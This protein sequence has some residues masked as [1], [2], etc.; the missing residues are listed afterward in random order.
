MSDSCENTDKEIWRERPGDFYADSIH[1]TEQGGIGLNVGGRVMVLP[2]RK[3]FELANDRL[4]ELDAPSPLRQAEKAV[5][6]AAEK[7]GELYLGPCE[8]NEPRFVEA[9]QNLFDSVRALSRLDEGG[10][11]AKTS[12]HRGGGE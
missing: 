7:W 3:W 6:E 2:V 10:S 4:N 11:D 9:R 12:N 5:I 1:V 8:Y